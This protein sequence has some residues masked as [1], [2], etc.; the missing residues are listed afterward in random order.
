VK[1]EIGQR[2]QIM[3]EGT[4]ASMMPGTG[5]LRGVFI[6]VLNDSEGG[7]LRLALTQEEMLNGNPAL[8]E[9]EAE[10]VEEVQPDGEETER[11]ED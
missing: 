9:L 4:I 3:F 11:N 7:I 6:A 1:Y 5:T 8:D 2:L 10:E